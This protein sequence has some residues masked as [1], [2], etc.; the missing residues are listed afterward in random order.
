MPVE[1]QPYW[2]M[3][4]NE[5]LPHVGAGLHR[6]WALVEPRRVRIKH[7]YDLIKARSI[8][9]AVWEGMPHI[10]DEGQNLCTIME[11]LRAYENISPRPLPTARRKR[12]MRA[13][14]ATC[15]LP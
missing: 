14:A 9:L 5:R 10:L 7:R 12:H 2:I 1:Y 4:S 15:R 3:V 6:V 11:A 13:K 8:S